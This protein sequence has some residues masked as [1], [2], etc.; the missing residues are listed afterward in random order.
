MTMLLNSSL[1]LARRESLALQQVTRKMTCSS[2]VKQVS[3]PLPKYLASRAPSKPCCLL[4]ARAFRSGLRR[5]RS[6]ALQIG[7]RVDAPT[8]FETLDCTEENVYQVVAEFREAGWFMF[9]IHP[10]CANIGITGDIVVKEVDGPF[11]T[12]ALTGKFWHRRATVLE[13]CASYLVARIPEVLE[14][15]VSSPDELE[16]VIR[17]EATGEVMMDRMS[18]D[19]NGDRGTL[20]YQGIDPD[21]RGPFGDLGGFSAGGSMFT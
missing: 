12:V 5:S 2:F 6:F 1:S 11:V 7:R 20:M 9:G 3:R 13:Q 4:D 18:P 14:V 19:Y 8:A 15:N 16:D 21:L 10:Q 17:D